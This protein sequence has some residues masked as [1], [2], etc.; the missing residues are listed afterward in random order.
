MQQIKAN[1]EGRTK[2]VANLIKDRLYYQ[3][4]PTKVAK[5]RS[6][7]SSKKKQRQQQSKAK[8]ERKPREKLDEEKDKEVI[9]QRKERIKQFNRET[10]NLPNSAFKTYFGK[11]AFENYG[12]GNFSGN[13]HLLSHNVMPHCGENHPKNQETYQSA[14]LNGHKYIKPIAEL[15]RKCDENYVPDDNHSTLSEK[16]RSKIPL[17]LDLPKPDLINADRFADKAESPRLAKSQ[18]VTIPRP[19]PSVEKPTKKSTLPARAVRPASSAQ[20]E[21][22]KKTIKSPGT[23][24]KPAGKT[25]KPAEKGKGKNKEPE[26]KQHPEEVPE[27]ELKFMN[28]R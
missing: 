10:R 27:K 28:E 16:Q 2:P 4:E 20:A 17:H 22:P 26:A 24:V 9:K 25:I 15:P 11:P 18:L 6:S 13:G 21:H 14:L 8:P 5:T 1:H 3:E 23:E 7:T 19:K 12:C